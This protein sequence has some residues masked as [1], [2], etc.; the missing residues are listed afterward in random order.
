MDLLA[1]CFHNS[2]IKPL[3]EIIVDLMKDDPSLGETFLR[4]CF[5]EDNCNYLM[6]IILECT[7][8]TARQQVAGLVRHIVQTLKERDGPKLFEQE[9]ITQEDGTKIEQP[10]SICAQFIMKS[11]SLLNTQVAKNWSRF[12]SFLEILYTFGCGP[13]KENDSSAGKITENGA[14]VIV[15]PTKPEK[16]DTLGLEFLMKVSFVEKACDF[17]LGKKSPLCAPGEKRAEMSGSFS[18]PN[19]TPLIKLLTKILTD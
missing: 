1:K 3:C 11:L 13:D 16:A 17:M 9:I 8:M 18:S 6:E 5:A 14:E 10:A 15:Y 7:D 19:F 4:Q 2:A 12:D